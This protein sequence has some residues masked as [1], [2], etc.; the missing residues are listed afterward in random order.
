MIGIFIFLHF[1]KKHFIITREDYIGRDENNM[2]TNID[3]PQINENGRV[4]F[5]NEYFQ[6]TWEPNAFPISEEEQ[7]IVQDYQLFFDIT[8]KELH[9]R[10]VAAYDLKNKQYIQDEE[11]LEEFANILD[12]SY[13]LDRYGFRKDEYGHELYEACP[14]CRTRNRPMYDDN[15]QIAHYCDCTRGRWDDQC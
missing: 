6:F 4:Y 3:F 7:K 13:E 5:S 11:K 2:H 12:T 8:Q 1:P 9:L 15:P 10:L 14:R